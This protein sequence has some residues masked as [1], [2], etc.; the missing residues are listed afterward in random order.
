[1]TLHVHQLYIK[2]SLKKQDKE[3]FFNLFYRNDTQLLVWDFLKYL[4]ILEEQILIFLNN[5]K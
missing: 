5:V 1:M 3:M 2:C 4:I